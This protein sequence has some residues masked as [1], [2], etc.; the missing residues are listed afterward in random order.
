MERS[1]FLSCGHV[2]YSDFNKGRYTVPIA[3]WT[4]DQFAERNL[5][6]LRTEIIKPHY[7]PKPI[8]DMKA[9]T[10]VGA[11]LVTLVG[12][13]GMLFCL[14]FL[15]SSDMAD[16]VGAGFPFVGGAILV[17]GGLLALSNLSR[18]PVSYRR[19]LIKT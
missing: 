18:G 15:F 19:Y 5:M 2:F 13:L 4:I 8:I 14:P 1:C 9:F 10:K 11:L 16:L 6:Q 7:E 17:A 12:V 3:H